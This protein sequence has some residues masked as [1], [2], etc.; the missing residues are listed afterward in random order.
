MDPSAASIVLRV[1]A[2]L[3][4]VAANGVFAAAEFAVAKAR[5]ARVASLAKRKVRF[6]RLV[7]RAVEDPEAFVAATQLGITMTSLGLGWI[8]EPVVARLID[9][10]LAVVPSPW[11]AVTSYAVSAT[12]AF[13]A[14]T[15]LHIVLGELVPKSLALRNAESVALLVV[16]PTVVFSRL[17]RPFI[18]LLDAV[19]DRILHV[20]GLHAPPGRHVAFEREELVML[21]S[22]SRRAGTVEREEESLVRRVFRLTDRTVGEVMVHRMNVIGV[23]QTASVEDAVAIIRDRGFSRLPVF[24]RKPE[25]IVGAVR[26]K[27]LLLEVAAGRGQTPV[28]NVMRPVLYVPETKPVVDLLEEM[29][30]GRSQLAVVLEEY[31]STAGI[32][33][34]EDLLEEIVGE[35]PG[36]SRPQPKLVHVQQPDRIVVDATIDLQTLND[37]LG[38]NLAGE[39]ATTLGGFIFYHLGTIPEPGT[40]FSLGNLEFTVENVIGRRIGRV[41]IRRRPAS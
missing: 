24:G 21:V 40:K 23:P 32:V 2:V 9:P 27:D 35:I 28:T 33:T 10:L 34:I 18:W 22:E 30:R 16:P 20:F 25:E 12:L 41:E 1:L 19:A 29:R 5:K 7:Q 36:E 8:G 15:A 31:G 6:A 11:P 17:F 37:L 38:I 14:I 26:A 39:Q 13:I 3:A 4:I